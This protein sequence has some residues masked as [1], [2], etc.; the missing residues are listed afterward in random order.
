M[1]RIGSVR[2][3]ATYAGSALVYRLDDVR[4]VTDPYHAFAAD[5]GAM[6]DGRLS[7][8]LAR[9]GPFTHVVASGSTPPAPFVLE[10]SVEDLYGD[11]RQATEPA[12]VMSIRFILINVG[13]PHQEVAYDRLIERRV[14]LSRASPDAL[15]RGYGTAVAQILLQL[16]TELRVQL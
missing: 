5:P 10:V 13:G 1:L 7:E 3:A 6:L 14:P 12:A 4:Y 16:A 8:W 2:V 11:F 15:V 9:I